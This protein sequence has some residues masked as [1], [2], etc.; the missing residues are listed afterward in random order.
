MAIPKPTSALEIT[1]VAAGALFGL[2]VVFPLIPLLL[3]L[4]VG[5][6]R[7]FFDVVVPGGR[8]YE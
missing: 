7:G 6:F 3:D 5:V 2:L 8:T 4:T 1:A